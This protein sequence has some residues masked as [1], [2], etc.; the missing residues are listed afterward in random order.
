VRFINS[1]AVAS[2]GLSQV[3]RIATSSAAALP[4][5]ATRGSHTGSA[6]GGHGNGKV[7][8]VEDGVYAQHLEALIDNEKLA[9]TDA[10][11]PEQWA[12]ESVRL[13]GAAW[14]PDRTNLDEQYYQRE[15]KVVDRQMALAGLRL[16]KLLNDSIGKMT[17][18]DFR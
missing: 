2:G 8:N 6:L 7:S 3:S 15:I 17:P 1:A 18:R 9:S 11:T 14:V 10:G 5:A 16:A 12:N 4:I 13:A